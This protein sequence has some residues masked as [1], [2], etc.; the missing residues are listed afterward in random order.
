MCLVINKNRKIVPDIQPRM[1]VIV[2]AQENPSSYNDIMNCLFSAQKMNTTI[3][4]Y[5]INATK[6][7]SLLQVLLREID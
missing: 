3:D 4:G 7:S 5:V 6:D 1:L 2:S